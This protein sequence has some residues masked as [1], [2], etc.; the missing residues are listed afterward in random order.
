[1]KGA[2]F[3]QGSLLG[4]NER[5]GPPL[6][7]EQAAGRPLVGILLEEAAASECFDQTVF[8]TS[9][10]TCDDPVVEY[11]RDAWPAVKTLRLETDSP[12]AFGAASRRSTLLTSADYSGVL[13]VEGFKA[14]APRFVQDSST[15]VFVLDVN[16]VPL[17]SRR[18]FQKALP[19]AKENGFCAGVGSSA[20]SLCGFTMRAFDRI[21]D[22]QRALRVGDAAAA[23]ERT[24]RA[25]AEIRREK[26]LASE[27]EIEAVY[28]WKRARAERYG[29][30]R[31]GL[32]AHT[33]RDWVSRH[34]DTAAREAF[35]GETAGEAVAI[36]TR[37]GVEMVHAAYA[38]PEPD[39]VP[40]AEEWVRQFEA[41]V[42]HREGQRRFFPDYPSYLEVELTSRC[43]L[44]CKFCPQ[45]KL[46]RPKGDLEFSAFEQLLDRVGEFVFLLNFSGFGEPTLHP[47]LF[48]FVRHAK[49]QEIP[50]VGIETNGT[51]ID[52]A[53][54]DGVFG[55]G[56]DVLM[57]N[58]DALDEAGALP[59]GSIYEFVR[60]FL[61]RRGDAQ[62]PFLVLQRVTMA[63][64]DQD[65]K[66][67]RDF[68]VWHDVADAVVIRPFN[69]YRATFPDKRAID[70]APLERGAC[71]KLLGSALVLSSGM[72]VMCEQCFDGQHVGEG[73]VLGVSGESPY[74]QELRVD[75][76]QGHV[77]EFCAPCTQWYQQDAAWTM[78]AAYRL[79]FER[80]LAH[81]ARRVAE[82]TALAVQGRATNDYA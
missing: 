39:D 72:P 62:R 10:E 28:G 73:E 36:T 31:G 38:S 66:I 64:A 27:E 47:R 13:S 40:A 52:E 54:L 63:V 26:Y 11:L 19:L 80:A 6:F 35:L 77:G 18:Y 69:T 82:T 14:I 45:T 7:M 5:D 23:R 30:S 56:L 2:L 55:S 79:W 8:V 44:A 48:D 1:M 65:K 61:G 67:Q 81:T 3:L 71:K 37:S 21:S 4:L 43:N 78:P 51:D 17:C 12:F 70:F 22:Y 68:T 53:F 25:M 57:V 33:L 60:R 74:F 20:T 16:G 46:T 50:R 15:V 24:E 42:P 34:G 32:L 49:S 29:L 75:Q 58:L 9:S 76:S 41:R 59:F